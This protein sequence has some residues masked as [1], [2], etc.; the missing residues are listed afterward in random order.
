MGTFKYCSHLSIGMRRRT[1]FPTKEEIEAVYH[2]PALRAL[3]AIR[4]L[5]IQ[6]KK[7]YQLVNEY[8]IKKRY[9]GFGKSIKYG[10]RVPESRREWKPPPLKPHSKRNHEHDKVAIKRLQELRD[11][12]WWVYPS[13][14][15][16]YPRPDLIAV[17]DGRILAVEVGTLEGDS[18]EPRRYTKLDG[19][20]KL[21]PE[22]EII[23]Y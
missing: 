8:G 14:L 5:G 2:D 11:D 22:V 9:R 19:L 17:K 15:W 10:T 21:F 4:I 6:N 13:D 16:G 7:F 12:G 23:P 1:E 18:D 20:R 3:E